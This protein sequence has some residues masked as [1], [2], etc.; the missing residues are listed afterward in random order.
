MILSDFKKE[1]Q[2][3]IL[4]PSLTAGLIAAIVTISME[5]SLAALICNLHAARLSI[6]AIGRYEELALGLRGLLERPARHVEGTARS[7]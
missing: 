7:R 5:I 2:P 4:L 3:K 6:R 1:F